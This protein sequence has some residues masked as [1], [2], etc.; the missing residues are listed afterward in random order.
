MDN[1]SFQ[2]LQDKVRGQV[3]TSDHADYDAARAVYNGMIDKRPAAILRVS[4]VADVMAAT[5]AKLEALGVAWTELPPL[6]D[7]DTP[8]DLARYRHRPHS[9]SRTSAAKMR[10]RASPKP[11]R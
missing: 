4:Q 6:W 5:R 2:A 9:A 10:P 3:I 7:L 1:S 11:T 8:D